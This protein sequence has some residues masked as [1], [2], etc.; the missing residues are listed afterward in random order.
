M[1]FDFV[2]SPVWHVCSVF[3]GCMVIIIVDMDI[4]MII[5]IMNGIIMDMVRGMAIMVIADVKMEMD[6]EMKGIAS[7]AKTL[8]AA[9]PMKKERYV[10]VFFFWIE[11]FWTA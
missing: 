3:I 2:C 10:F 5:I 1:D 8:G 4:I 11:Y 6:T 9:L 7:L